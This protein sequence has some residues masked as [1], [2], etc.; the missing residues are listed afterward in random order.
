MNAKCKNRAKGL[1]RATIWGIPMGR[2]NSGGTH[3]FKTYRPFPHTSPFADLS[4]ISAT[5]AVRMFSGRLG[6]VS[7]MRA[8]LGLVA[9]AFRIA[10]V[11]RR[12]CHA[13]RVQFCGPVVVRKLSGTNAPVT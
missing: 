9:R 5:I 11:R 2:V 6:Q 8:R 7:T 10:M 12:F 4:T 1:L 13:S 3:C